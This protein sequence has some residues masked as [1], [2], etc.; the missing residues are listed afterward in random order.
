[1]T[2]TS[3]TL[4][5]IVGEAVLEDRLVRDLHRAGATGHTVTTSHGSGSRGVRA[6]L[7]GEGNVRVEVV[8]R[9]EV[10]AAIL[11]VLAE[12]YFPHYA[13]IAWQTEVEVLRGDKFA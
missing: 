4:L 3:L 1:V 5:T 6:G 2:T 9:P 10:A 7:G 8:V 11:D 13:V 12:R